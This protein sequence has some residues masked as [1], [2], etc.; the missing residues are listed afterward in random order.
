LLVA[1]SQLYGAQTVAG[2]DRHC[3]CPSQTLTSPSE[4]PLQVPALQTVPLGYRRQWPWPSHVPSSPQ[5]EAPAAVHVPG[6]AATP[7]A[8]NVQMPGALWSLHVLQ[9]SWQG[10]LQQMPSTQKP[11][12]QSR[13]QPQGC[14]F[15]WC[16]PASAVHAPVPLSVVRPPLSQPPPQPVRASSRAQAT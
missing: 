5:V 4:A 1:E 2:P 14:P 11:L 10:L 7:F 16:P 15:T 8:M 13:L 6:G 3:P 9:V 12:W